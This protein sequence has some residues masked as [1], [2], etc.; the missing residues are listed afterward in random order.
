MPQETGPETVTSM[1]AG[2]QKIRKTFVPW[3]V[4]VLNLLWF[5]RSVRAQIL[6]VFIA[7]NLVAASIAGSVIILK[8]SASTRIEIAASMR[9][10]ELMANEA[11]QLVQQGIPAEQFLQTLP[12]QLRFLRHVRIR[13]RDADGQLVS[14]HATERTEPSRED[15]RAPAPAWFAMLIGPPI[16]RHEVAVVVGGRNIGTVEMVSEPRDEIAEVWENSV[17]LATVAGVTVLVITGILYLVLGRVLDPLIALGGGLRRLEQR[18]YKMRLARPKVLEFAAIVDRFNALAGALDEARAENIALNR[19]MITAQDDE[20]RRTALELHDEVGP[21]LFGL[22]ANVA[23][24]AK[25]A[26]GLPG[27][28]AAA[29]QE[30]VRELAAIIDHLQ[31]INRSMLNRLRPM[32]LGHVPL[33]EIIA[34]LVRD[35]AREH[36][37]I[38]FTHD[39]ETL[40]RSYGDTIDLTL[41]RCVQESLTN[42]IRHA[43][44]RSIDVKVAVGGAASFP[45]AEQL[46]P[47]GGGRS[48]R[49]SGPGGGG[50]ASPFEASPSAHPGLP[51]AVRPSPFRGGWANGIALPGGAGKKDSIAAWLELTVRDDGDG[52]AAGQA[53]GFGLRG[54]QERV[55]A[56]G[57]E[58]AVEATSG[59]GTCVRILVPLPP[60]QLPPYPFQDAGE[61]GDGAADYAGTSP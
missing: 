42:A 13:V 11:V 43:N 15:S 16:E 28:A 52:I 8:A 34:E 21:S 37:H 14:D 59:C 32:A 60:P 4:R 57:G 2:A 44:A 39:L 40:D 12:G 30:R 23:S 5:G 10:A 36:P 26:A 22:K 17:A 61:G 35:R 58:F 20:R 50:S 49:D 6:L 54:M 45:S 56:L 31:G 41:Y 9:L 1:R 18:D 38:A 29:V 3:R 33:P 46:P 19:R 47:P 25:A 27:A 55:Q 48:A 24:I 7:I 53:P 51:S